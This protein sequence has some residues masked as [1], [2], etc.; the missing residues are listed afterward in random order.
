MTLVVCS[1]VGNRRNILFQKVGKDDIIAFVKINN[2]INNTNKNGPY[3]E[4]WGT[5]VFTDIQSGQS[6]FLYDL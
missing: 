6:S 4:P 3:T 1:D 5:P 2:E